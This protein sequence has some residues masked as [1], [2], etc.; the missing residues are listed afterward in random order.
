MKIELRPIGDVHP[1]ARNPRLNDG[2]V[3]AVAESIRQFGFQ[4]PIVVDAGGVIIIGHTRLKAAELLGLTAV[5]SRARVRSAER[6][7]V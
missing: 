3:A 6:L 4:Q 7:D 1:Y 5:R 2:A